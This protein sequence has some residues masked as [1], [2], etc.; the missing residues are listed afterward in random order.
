MGREERGKAER[1]PKEREREREKRERERD[2]RMFKKFSKQ[3]SVSAFTQVKTSVQRGIRANICAEYPL[4]EEGGLIDLLIPKKES[5][6][7]A[8]CEGKVEIVCVNSVPLFY[9]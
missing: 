7:I 1:R 9:K 8:K 4:L 2:E 6:I 5:V 3:E